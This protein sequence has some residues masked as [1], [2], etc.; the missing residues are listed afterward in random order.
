MDRDDQEIRDF[1]VDNTQLLDFDEEEIEDQ[2]SDLS[3]VPLK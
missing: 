2:I 1:E 3:Q